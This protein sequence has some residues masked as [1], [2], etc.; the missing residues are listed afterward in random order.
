MQEHDRGPKI[1]LIIIR[2]LTVKGTRKGGLG[3]TPLEL[4]ILEKLYYLRKRD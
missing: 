2:A 3:L 1:R 4:D